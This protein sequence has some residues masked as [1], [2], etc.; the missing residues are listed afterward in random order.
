TGKGNAVTS[1]A[2][3]SITVTDPEAAGPVN[4]PPTVTL[5][6]PANGSSTVDQSPVVVEARATDPLDIV[7]K[8]E[9]FDGT[10]SL[11]AV[12]TPPYRI[13]WTASPPG[14]HSLR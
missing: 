4:Q 6:S 1:S 13:L 11:G 7:A 3:V 10:V 8:V 14:I 9:F 2:P 12:Q 5:L